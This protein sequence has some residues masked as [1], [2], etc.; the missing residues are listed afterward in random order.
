M[1]SVIMFRQDLW[2]LVLLALEGLSLHNLWT[3]ESSLNGPRSAR[4][5]LDP[6]R[7]SWLPVQRSSFGSAPAIKR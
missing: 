5:V 6:T 3:G 1:A 2:F 7:G 4:A